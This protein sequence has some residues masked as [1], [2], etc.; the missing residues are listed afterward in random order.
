MAAGLQET[1]SPTA[2]SA[3]VCTW[4]CGST[5]A[6]GG[7]ECVSGGWNGPLCNYFCAYRG[8]VCVSVWVGIAFQTEMGFI[9]IA[10]ASK[11]EAP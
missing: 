8:C 1:D 7:G 5:R 4:L 2:G 9:L 10:C 3:A 6:L 11:S